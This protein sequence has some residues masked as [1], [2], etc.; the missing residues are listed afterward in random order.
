M[1]NK[2]VGAL[3]SALKSSFFLSHSI[4]GLIADKPSVLKTLEH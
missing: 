3:I 4:L 2:L 1:H